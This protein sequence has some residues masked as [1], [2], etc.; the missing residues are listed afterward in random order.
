[1][2]DPSG[3]TKRSTYSREDDSARRLWLTQRTKANP[4]DHRSND[5]EDEQPVSSLVREIAA[6][7]PEASK[8]LIH[9]RDRL[10]LD[11]QG[12]QLVENPFAKLVLNR[13]RQGDKGDA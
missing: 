8:T 13:I 4:W 11:T 10:S 9:Q 7:A 1:M 2:L 6:R 3:D 5:A 12:P